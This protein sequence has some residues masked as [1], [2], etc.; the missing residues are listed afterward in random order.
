LGLYLG[1]LAA[2]SQITTD[3]SAY[4]NRKLT[5]EEANIVS[6]YYQQ[7]GDNSAVTGGIGT[8][9]LTDVS[10]FFDIKL[11]MYDGKFRKHSFDIGLGVDHYTSAS[12]DNIDPK[13]VLTAA[14]NG[15]TISS[16]SSASH[17]D[18]RIYPN[19]NWSVENNHAATF[20]AGLSFSHEYDYTSRGVSALF[21]K[22]T[23]D[24]SGEFSM[25][26]QAYLDNL[27]IIKPIEFQAPENIAEEYGHRH[28][29]TASRNSFSADLSYSQII[30]KRLQIMFLAGAIYQKGYLSL[31]FHRIYFNDGAKGIER[32]PDNRLKIPLGIRANYF[33]GDN[34]IFRAFYRYYQD[35]WGL[36][37]NTV[38]LETVYKITPFLSV[39]PFYRY[40]KQSAIDYFAPYKEH[41]SSEEFY[42]SNYDLSAFDAHFFGAGIRIIPPK[43]IGWEHFNMLEIRY[44]HYNQTTGLAS[45]I[46]SLNIRI[47]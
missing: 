24:K 8:E 17:S 11:N 44:G 39:T 5:M 23:N 32:L 20:G 35:S 30:N 15:K 46:I 34:I 6:S 25:N 41:L 19:L 18:T 33:L 27:K 42:S 43:G 1:F 13:P 4:K 37:A 7:D 12:S 47:R 3:S 31:P 16:A 45:N 38:S 36:K 22:K 9:K 2:F 14:S 21:A 40:H 26:L 29:P 28:Y 10:N